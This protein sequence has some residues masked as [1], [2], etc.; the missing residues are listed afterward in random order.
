MHIVFLSA[1]LPLTKTFIL[2]D[3]VLA[4]TPY[5]HV[6]KVTSH[7]QQYT[8]IE[9]FR[10]LLE[11]HASL[12]HCL[13][14]GQ[15]TS[16]LAGE[17]RAGKTLKAPREWVVF[18]FDRV[19]AADHTEVV[20]KYLPPE[21]QNVSY[22]AQ[23]SASMFKLEVKKWSGHIFMLLKTPVEDQRVKQWFEHI[24]FRLP[25]LQAQ[26]SLS[27]SL[28]A[29]HW[30]LDRTAAYNSKLIYIAPPRCHGY[31]PEVTKPIVLVKRKQPSLTIPSFTPIDNVDVR[32]KINELRRN[33]GLGEIAYSTVVFEGE[34]VLRDAGP[35]AI[36]GMRNS[37]DHYVRFN[38][39]GGDS[40]AYFIDLRKPDLIRNFKGEPF[41]KT[42]EVAP[43]LY[44]ALR[45][46]APKAVSK[47]PLDPGSEVL[48]FY[49]TNRGAAIKTGMYSAVSRHLRLDD[50][51]ETAARAWLT[52]FGLVQKTA[53]PHIDIVFDPTSDVQYVH[54]ST[55]V[56]TF[57]A[58]KYMARAKTSDKPS[59]LAELPPIIGRLIHHILGSP[60]DER[61]VAHFVNWLAHIYQTRTRTSTAWVLHGV[62]GTGKG[63]F[64]NRVL[65]PVFGVEQV[66]ELQFG[67]VT[68]QFNA[69]LENKLFVVFDEADVKAVENQ[70]ELMSKLKHWITEPTIEINQ[71]GVK[72]YPV[73]NHCNFIFS[74]NER[75]PVAPSNDDRRFNIAERQDQKIYLTPNE[76][77]ALTEGVE[78]DA[79]ADVLQRWPVDSLAVST[80]FDTEAKV[81]IHEAA[82]SINQLVAEAIMRGD[83]QFFIDRMPSD[84]EA[85]AD[86]YN[87]FNPMGLFKEVVARCAA[88]AAKGE[89]M[90]ITDSDLFALFRALIP[91]ERYFQDSKTWRL[92]HY[93]TLGLD[94]DKQ[95]RDPDDWSKRKRGLLVHWKKPATNVPA[96]PVKDNVT[97]IQ[98]RGK[99]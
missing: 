39:N 29:L 66:R 19:D 49:A 5:P 75:T 6:T 84:A 86:F 41:L 33:A 15:L 82:T 50:S 53:L 44:K 26:I 56:N 80:T 51:T 12:G 83:L 96:A 70:S 8:T 58:T 74:S 91:D 77:I 28:Q 65:G 37:G 81:A 85:A 25:A 42:E 89:P 43:D 52:E 14:N 92:R 88:A 17:S 62:Q 94:V 55:L 54:G 18:D 61:L 64:V 38:L 79:F 60:T 10:A 87:K 16:P 4:A 22:I 90:L 71:K 97:S 13:F 76:Q 93:K 45:K 73:K 36:E 30:P 11:A 32:Q 98:K 3:G 34:E 31:T 78:L 35:C 20:Q 48:A 99:K 7:H 63:T 23:L 9:Q 21:C 69:F 72:T 27:D 68:S 67:M 1:A 2:R 47:P 40:Y 57:Q 59:T 24:N 46:A 95:H